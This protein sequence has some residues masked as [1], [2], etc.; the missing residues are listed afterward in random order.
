MT[1][2][3]REGAQRAY[4]VLKIDEL[5]RLSATGEIERYYRLQIK[6]RGGVVRT[7][8]VGERDFTEEKVAQVLKETA[9]VADKILSL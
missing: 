6:T 9:A 1:T 8:D 4:Q 2:E 7:V 5:T 3:R